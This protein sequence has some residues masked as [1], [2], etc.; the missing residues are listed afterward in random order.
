MSVGE[1][2]LSLVWLAWPH[3]GFLALI[4]AVL[5]R[6]NSSALEM[7][8]RGCIAAEGGKERELSSRGRRHG[9]WDVY[10]PVT[11]WLWLQHSHQ[12]SGFPAP[13]QK[14][15][16]PSAIWIKPLGFPKEKLFPNRIFFF[17]CRKDFLITDSTGSYIESQNAR[18][19]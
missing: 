15:S 8:R 4:S 10:V 19:D 18:I 5:R 7:H 11:K 2:V 13:G 9:M 12:L 16:V 17:F 1:D 6:W 14:Y 3:G